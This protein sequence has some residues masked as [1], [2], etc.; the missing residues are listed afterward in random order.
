MAAVCGVAAPPA[1][2]VSLSSLSEHCA[3]VLTVHIA[4]F[5]LARLLV[6]VERELAGKEVLSTLVIEGLLRTRRT[7]GQEGGM[8]RGKKERRERMSDVEEII[9]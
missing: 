6:L 7:E 3:V 1:G 8:E 9:T 5:L 2:P 4:R